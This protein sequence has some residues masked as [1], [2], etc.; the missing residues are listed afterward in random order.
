MEQVLREGRPAMFFVARRP[1]D[2]GDRAGVTARRR[3]YGIFR[4]LGAK[5]VIVAEGPGISA[6]RSSCSPRAAPRR[7]FAR[8]ESDSWT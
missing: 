5:Q 3:R 7:F 2:C 4:R 8:A 1:A 6:T